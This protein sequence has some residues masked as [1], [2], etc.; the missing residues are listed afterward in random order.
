MSGIM[1]DNVTI[2]KVKLRKY[3]TKQ[4]IKNPTNIEFK[5]SSVFNSFSIA[6]VI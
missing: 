1:I 6:S 4:G 2:K 5:L 3:V